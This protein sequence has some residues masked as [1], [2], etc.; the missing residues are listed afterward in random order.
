MNTTKPTATE[1]SIFIDYCQEFYDRD[2][3]RSLYPF[4][5][6][7]EIYRAVMEYLES[8]T[9][10]FDGDSIDRENVRDIICANRKKENSGTHDFDQ[11]VKET[12]KELNK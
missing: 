11:A 7:M 2:R 12:Q 3:A 8:T 1:I 6:S 9:I 4:A 5:H 10:P